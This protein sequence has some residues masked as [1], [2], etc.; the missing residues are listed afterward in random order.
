MGLYTLGYG[1]TVW[2]NGNRVN[3]LDPAITQEMADS[4]LRDRVQAYR[5]MAAEFITAPLTGPELDGVVLYLMYNHD[6]RQRAKLS[7]SSFIKAINSDTDRASNIFDIWLNSRL[8]KWPAAKPRQ[9]EES[10]YFLFA[11]YQRTTF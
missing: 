2:P 3:G 4:Y 1:M 11:D 7:A 6:W 8:M 5:G 10:G 9:P